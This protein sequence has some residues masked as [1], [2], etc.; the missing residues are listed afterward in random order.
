MTLTNKIASRVDRINELETGYDV[1]RYLK[2]IAEEHGLAKFT[3]MTIS[4]DD[5]KLS[6]ISVVNNWDPELLSVY[7]DNGL[8]AR[9][10]ILN[11]CRTSSRPLEIDIET[12]PQDRDNAER[13]L[14]VE[15]FTD[16]KMS[17]GIAYPVHDSSGMRGTISFSG[18]EIDLSNDDALAL[19]L[20]SLYAFD[21]LITTQNAS[22]KAGPN[23]SDRERDCLNWT[24][25]GKTSSEIAL[26]L[27]LSDHTVN[28]YLTA[29]CRKLDAVNRVQAV[30]KAIRLGLLS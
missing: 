10:P 18:S 30:A 17:K 27:E 2:S 21:H 13:N 6:D 7:D 23:L 19:H 3:V 16:F 1:F 5:T 14:T 4:H 25:A 20:I 8:A 24:A 28:H 9:S 12:L 22:P 26:I 15:L 11:H 29:A